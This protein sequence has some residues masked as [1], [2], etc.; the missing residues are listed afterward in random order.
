MTTFS[1]CV[2]VTHLSLGQVGRVVEIR[3]H[4]LKG[5]IKHLIPEVSIVNHGLG[6][7][8]LQKVSDR[9]T[10]IGTNRNKT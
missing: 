2:A 3:Q 8:F 1:R 6:Q 10:W 7:V 4:H 5:V 9:I